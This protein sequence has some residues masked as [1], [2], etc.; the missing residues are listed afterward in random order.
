[1]RHWPRP[2]KDESGIALVTGLL[3]LMSLTAIGVFATNVTIVHQD[4]SANLKASKQ[5]FYLAEAGIQHAKW[6]LTE[7]H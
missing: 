4:I 5:E 6:F 7:W 3:I 2:I 1:M